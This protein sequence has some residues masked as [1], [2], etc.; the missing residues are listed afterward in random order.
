MYDTYRHIKQ[1]LLIY[2]ENVHAHM[3]YVKC[4]SR[5]HVVSTDNIMSD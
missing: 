4:I 1:K 2:Y 3:E 5:V